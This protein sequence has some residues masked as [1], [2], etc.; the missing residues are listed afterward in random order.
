MT[1]MLVEV[2]V[3]KVVVVCGGGSVV[4]AKLV[5]LRHPI[6]RRSAY[7]TYSFL[8][9]KEKKDKNNLKTLMHTNL[10]RRRENETVF[11]KSERQQVGVL[12]G[13]SAFVFARTS[14]RGQRK[15]SDGCKSHLLV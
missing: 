13:D 6:A 10:M 15:R 1:E 4:L 2:M 3:M 12:R 14:S 11:F 7:I 8:V 5:F 9:S